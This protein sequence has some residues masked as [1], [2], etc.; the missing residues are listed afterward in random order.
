MDS[1]I[2]GQARRTSRG[3][4]ITTLAPGEEVVIHLRGAAAQAI[5]A[6]GGR[7]LGV[8]ATAIRLHATWSRFCLT[9]NATTGVVLVPWSR[10]DRVRIEAAS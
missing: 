2:N 8:D 4:T 10:I 5:N 7:V 9:P 1:S 3:G 6:Y